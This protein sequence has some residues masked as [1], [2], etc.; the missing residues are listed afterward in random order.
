MSSTGVQSQRTTDWIQRMTKTIKV[1]NNQGKEQEYEEG[2]AKTS[3]T[4]WVI[5][6]NPAMKICYELEI[7]LFE[8]DTQ[9]T[10]AHQEVSES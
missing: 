7:I 2:K 8:I 5:R 3:G 6:I 9:E 10:Q 4:E 1:N